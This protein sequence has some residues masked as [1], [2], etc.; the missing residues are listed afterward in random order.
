MKRVR[1]LYP[2][3]IG[4]ENLRLAIAEVKKLAHGARI[5]VSTAT[6]LLSRLGQLRHYNSV[7][8]YARIVKPKT[9]KALK[10]IVRDYM[11]KER[12]KWIISTA[13]P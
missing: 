1:N 12:R 7:R 5:S 13:H 3:L 10:N 4:D 9:Q 11:R 2:K 8:L 6:G